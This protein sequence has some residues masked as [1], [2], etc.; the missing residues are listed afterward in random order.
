MLCRSINRFLPFTTQTSRPRTTWSQRNSHS[1]SPVLLEAR[2]QM[3]I[4]SPVFEP[5]QVAHAPNTCQSI[6]RTHRGD[7]LVQVAWPLK[8]NQDRTIPE[9]EKATAEGISSM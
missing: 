9:D 6:V 7:F 4:K 1:S 8:W 3:E 5:V 2:T